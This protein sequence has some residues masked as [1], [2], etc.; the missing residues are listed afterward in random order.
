MI[1]LT[2]LIIFEKKNLR[3][4]VSGSLQMLLRIDEELGA[5]I[6]LALNFELEELYWDLRGWFFEN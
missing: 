5:E 3:F 1:T 2:A 6:L 4:W